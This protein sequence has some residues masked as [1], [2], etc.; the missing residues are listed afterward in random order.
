MITKNVAGMR[1]IKKHMARLPPEDGK[2]A[3]AAL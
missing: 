1:L 3:E 2:A